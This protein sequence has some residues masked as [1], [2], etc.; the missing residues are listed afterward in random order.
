MSKKYPIIRTCSKCGNV[1]Q[2]DIDKKEAAFDLIDINKVL[3]KK[4]PKCQSEKFTTYGVQPDM[5]D[6]LFNA[7]AISEDLHISPQDEDLLLADERHLNNIIRLIDSE[8]TVKLK[9]D[10]LFETLCV[11]VYDITENDGNDLIKQQVIDELNKRIELL[12][13]ADDWIMDYIK[14][15]VYP[16]LSIDDEK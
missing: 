12:K 4:C 2:I 16:Q 15:K 13:E 11:M 8:S 10:I 1:E 14:D 3:G 7:W 9:R 5:D 6:E